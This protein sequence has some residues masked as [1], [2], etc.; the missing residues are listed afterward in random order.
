MNKSP[1]TIALVELYVLF[2]FLVLIFALFMIPRL[3][4]TP[5]SLTVLAAALVL[6]IVIALAYGI[7]VV[8]Y[9]PPFGKRLLR[10]APQT[11]KISPAVR[12]TMF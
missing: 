9:Q 8:Q 7:F 12:K 6:N 1:R 5:F 4:P 11:V 10:L 2:N 3:Q